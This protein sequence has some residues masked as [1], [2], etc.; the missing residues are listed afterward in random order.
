MPAAATSWDAFGAALNEAQR[1][2]AEGRFGDFMTLGTRLERSAA[3]LTPPPPEQIPALQ[4]QFAELFGV[5]SHIE[6]VRGALAG[7]RQ[8]AYGPRAAP[9]PPAR[10][11]FDQRG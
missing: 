11:M 4:K 1:A 9:R 6:A 2:A 5:L 10:R 7:I 8:G 3:T